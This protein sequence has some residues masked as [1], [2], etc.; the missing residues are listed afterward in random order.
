M[1]SD[2]TRLLNHGI[3]ANSEYAVPVDGNP[4]S[5]FNN[6]YPRAVPGCINHGSIGKDRNPHRFF[7]PVH[8]LVSIATWF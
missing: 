7:F 6:G 8:H 4:N 5:T 1:P 3:N 2:I